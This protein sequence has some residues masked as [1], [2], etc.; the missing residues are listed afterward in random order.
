MYMC[1]KVFCI[2]LTLGILLANGTTANAQSGSNKGKT[3]RQGRNMA[4]PAGTLTS[5]QLGAAHGIDGRA[6][7]VSRS[8][9]GKA[10]ASTGEGRNSISTPRVSASPLLGAPKGYDE[11]YGANLGEELGGKQFA[12]PSE[13]YSRTPVER[14]LSPESAARVASYAGQSNQGKGLARNNTAASVSYRASHS[15]SPDGDHG[16]IGRSNIYRSPW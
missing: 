9:D 8:S 14:L 11:R 15:G 6:T 12:D 3:R 2:F 1:K 10:P 7:G 4:M 5:P 13:G 16:T